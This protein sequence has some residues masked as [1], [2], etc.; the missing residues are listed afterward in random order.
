MSERFTRDARAVVVGAQH[1][2]RAL[3]HEEIVAQHLLLALLDVDGIA[4]RVL[5][6]IEVRRDAIVT[7]MATLGSSDA[8]A[9]DLIG[10]DLDAVRSQ[11][12]TTFGPGALDRRRRRPTGRIRRRLLGEHVPFSAGAKKALELALREAQALQHTYI[13]TEHILLGLAANPHGPVA[14]TLRRLGVA[15]DYETVKTTVLDELVRMP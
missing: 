2:A 9:L 7:D 8:Q 12:E 5:R 15:G 11:V 14:G 10:I 1:E 3:G 4:A 13:G 6:R